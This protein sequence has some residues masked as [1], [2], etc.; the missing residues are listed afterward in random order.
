MF[1]FALFPIFV[2]KIFPVARVVISKS[3]GTRCVKKQ[4][5]SH[6]RTCH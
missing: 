2:P 3:G 1:V 4:R 5:A 6:T